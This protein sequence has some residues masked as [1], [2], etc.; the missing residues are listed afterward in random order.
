MQT[1]CNTCFDTMI[2]A[3]LMFIYLYIISVYDHIS[4]DMLTNNN[5]SSRDNCSL[6]R[7][8]IS[9]LTS[10]ILSDAH[11]WKHTL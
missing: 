10:L 8:L 6:H 4:I 1:K 2:H 7:E 5:I 9:L 11:W 3:M